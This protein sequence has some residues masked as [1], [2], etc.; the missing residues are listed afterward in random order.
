MLRDRKF[1]LQVLAMVLLAGSMIGAAVGNSVHAAPMKALAQQGTP[2]TY[3]PTNTLTPTPTV[4]LT[5]TLTPTPTNTPTGTLTQA[6][7]PTSTS[8]SP[9]T[10]TPSA[11][12]TASITQTSTSTPTPSETATASHTYT[13]T[14]TS[15]RTSTPTNTGTLPTLTSTPTAPAH[16]VISE[17]RSTGPL[18]ADDE[19]VELYNPTGAP[20]N[21]G[22]WLIYTSSGCG[23]SISALISIYQGTVLQPGQHYLVAA[24]PSFSSIAYSDMR[25]SPGIADSGGLALF[26]AGTVIDQVGMCSTTY[27]KEGTTLTP[28]PSAPDV[29]TP[30][31]LPTI[32]NKSYERKPGGDT[33]CYDT[34]NNANDFK[35][36]YPSNPQTQ[37][38]NSVMCAGVVLTSPTPTRT[39]TITPTY[40]HTPVPT[41][42]PAVA[43]LNE[44]LPRPHMDWNGDGTANVGD[45]YIEIINLGSTDLSVQ[46]WILDTGV[47]SKITFN[48]PDLTLQPRQIATF[49][50][51][52]TGIR[53]SD[54]G[55][56]V[57]LVRSDGRI[58]DAYTYP[59]IEV[60]DRTYCRLPNG[61]GIWGFA[62]LASPGK[63]NTSIYNV[64]PA[65]VP[66]GDTIC[67]QVY[68]VPQSLVIAECDGF[69]SDIVRYPGERRFWL[70]GHWK[71]DVFF[72]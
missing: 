7:T 51:S 64:T 29:G 21:I 46:G 31:P 27:Y 58:M 44:F 3:T 52:E 39:S 57:R 19:F 60:A 71:W 62:C 22:N 56:T 16:I 17:F 47:N 41:A 26:S 54:G 15:T 53:L 20:V 40:T 70:L 32:S 14:H 4:T 68:L 9:V 6:N 35:L 50:S 13:P 1:F 10:P 43:V 33:S 8:T 38:S 34:D 36:I 23:T 25:F 66:G 69:G 59:V 24:Y 49:F 61:T 5:A 12:L 63:P 11:T 37:S 28:L 72:E 2:P 30:T 48:I 18:G 45:E 67:S 55:G 65:S 42:Y